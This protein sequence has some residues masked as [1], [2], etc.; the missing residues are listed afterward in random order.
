[1]SLRKLGV[2]LVFLVGATIGGLA[3]AFCGVLQARGV[4]T[5]P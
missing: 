4:R 1:M 3:M 5:V 2:G